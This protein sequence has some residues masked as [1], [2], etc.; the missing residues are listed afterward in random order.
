MAF[1]L[2]EA[3]RKRAVPFVFVSGYGQN[4]VPRH[5]ADIGFFN[6]PVEPADLTVALLAVA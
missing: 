3:L 6:K 5:L 4:I 1:P 2:A